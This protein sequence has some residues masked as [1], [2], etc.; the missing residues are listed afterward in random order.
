MRTKGAEYLPCYNTLQRTIMQLKRV[1]PLIVSVLAV[2]IA[3]LPAPG[4]PAVASMD[5][6]EVLDVTGFS[7]KCECGRR[8]LHR[9][10]YFV[11]T[12]PAHTVLYRSHWR[13]RC[14]IQLDRSVQRRG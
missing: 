3:G 5:W 8:P 9:F 10:K 1:S 14:P 6:I 2:C 4:V 13:R 7:G 12:T 11:A